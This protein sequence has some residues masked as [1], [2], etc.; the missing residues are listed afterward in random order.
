MLGLFWLV[1]GEMLRW[2]LLGGGTGNAF[3]LAGVAGGASTASSYGKQNNLRIIIL[4][5]PKQHI[6]FKGEKIK[7]KIQ[8]KARINYRY[9]ICVYF[10]HKKPF[11]TSGFA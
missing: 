6:T 2:L 4:K 7:D 3:L 8:K 1:P 11:L 10:P 5:I 9:Q